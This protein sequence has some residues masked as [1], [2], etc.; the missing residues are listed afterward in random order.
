MSIT[1]TAKGVANSKTSGTTLTISSVALVKGSMLEVA[2]GYDDVNGHPTSVKW[3]NRL[4]NNK[5]SRDSVGIDIALS[6]WVLPSVKN[7][8]TRDIVATWSGSIV[9]RTM[10][11]SQ[12]VGANRIDKKAGN[13]DKVGTTDPVTGTT[14]TLSTDAGFAT[15]YFVA[16]GPASDAIGIAQIRDATVLAAATIG[17]RSGTVGAPPVSN[18]TITEAFLEL[19]TD[20]PT[21]GTLNATSRLWESVIVVA[22]DSVVNKVGI[23]I[24]DLLDIDL[25]FEGHT[26]SLDPDGA[27]FNFNDDTDEWEVYDVG[28]TSTRI[29][30]LDADDGW[31]AD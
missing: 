19:T 25:L 18:V 30:Y 22:R 2:L 4:L 6:V 21:D 11:A 13:S 16:Q 10:V 1:R 29:G 14:A 24:S 8:S 31:T 23:T 17:Q 15:C 5:V 28:D 9:E 7:G 27:F 20:D 3:G 26:P 12:L